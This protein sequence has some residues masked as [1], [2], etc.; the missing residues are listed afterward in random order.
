MNKVIISAG[1]VSLPGELIDSPTAR[2][3]WDALPVE[4]GA[5]TWGE[6]IYFEIPVD[7][8]QAP[9]AR[10]AV[11][12]GEIGYWPAGRALCLFFG[13]TPAS[14]DNRPRAASPVNIVG[15]ILGDATRLRAVQDGDGVRVV[16]ESAEKT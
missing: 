7:V 13:P 8:D 15:R 10:A 9:D 6:E 16:R 5:K 2:M 14:T 1:D 11:E 3:I 12:V 4:G